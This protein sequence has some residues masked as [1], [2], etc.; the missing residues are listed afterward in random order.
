[1]VV[2]KE[3]LK[4]NRD[5]LEVGQ[6]SDDGRF[7][8]EHT[9]NSSTCSAHSEPSVLNFFEPDVVSHLEVHRVEAEFSWNGTIAEH[10][11]GRHP[12]SVKDEL[13]KATE[14][15]NL[16]QTGGG[17]LI[18]SLGGERVLKLGTWKMDEFL[19]DNTDEGEH[20]NTAMLDLGLL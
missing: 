18:E 17:N 7:E 9:V 2:G 10:V 13:A 20:S 8:Q 19:N 15:E 16:P 11:G 1:M 6:L 3:I 4:V 12:T 5:G 14:K